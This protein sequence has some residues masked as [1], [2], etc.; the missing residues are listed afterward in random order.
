MRF[1]FLF[2]LLFSS[3]A[4]AESPFR[5]PVEFLRKNLIDFRVGPGYTA[6]EN[7]RAYS[8][9]KSQQAGA[10]HG[11]VPIYDFR[12]GPVN[13]SNI[14]SQAGFTK[15][16]GLRI[17][18]LFN[19]TGDSYESD[20]LADRRKSLFAGGFLGFNFLTLYAYADVF[21]S[22]HA[23]AIYAAQLSPTLFKISGNAFY[24]I[25]ELEHMNRLYVDYYFG[26]RKFEATTRLPAYDGRATNNFSGTLLY[27]YTISKRAEFL[28]WGGEKRYGVGVTNSPTVTLKHQ[29]QAGIGWLFRIM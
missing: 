5:D 22:S 23:G 25:L 21:K 6:F 26:I 18:L 10:R 27:V 8:S 16:K 17:G 3:V 2:S 20:G 12:I 24:L 4:S 15:G 13:I 14:Y 7:T 11:P 19:Y 29:Y 1:I 9:Q 28:L